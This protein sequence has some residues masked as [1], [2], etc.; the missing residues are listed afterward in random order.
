MLA[1]CV[2][3]RMLPTKDRHQKDHGDNIS[4][5]FNRNVPRRRGEF[6]GRSPRPGCKHQITS[7]LFF[8]KYLNHHWICQSTHTVPKLQGLLIHWGSNN[9]PPPRFSSNLSGRLKVPCPDHTNVSVRFQ[10][11]SNSWEYVEK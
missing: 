6:G 7:S 5:H 8:Q 3:H 4:T 10:R 1:E 2:C 9:L 11:R